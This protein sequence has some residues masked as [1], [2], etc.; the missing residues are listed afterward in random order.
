MCAPKRWQQR[1]GSLRRFFAVVPIADAQHVFGAAFFDSRM[2]LVRY[3]RERFLQGGSRCCRQQLDGIVILPGH[4]LRTTKHVARLRLRRLGPP[5]RNF[6]G[7]QRRWR[8]SA[9]RRYCGTG[10][11]WRQDF[12]E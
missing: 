6:R 7:E 9:A 5:R 12:R 2:R 4:G 11:A 1:L 10:C 3:Q 8:R